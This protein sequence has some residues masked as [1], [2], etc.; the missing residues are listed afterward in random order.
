MIKKIF[1]AFCL[2][3]SFVAAKAQIPTLGFQIGSTSNDQGRV[4]R[5]APNGN[6]CIAGKF[7]GTMDLDPGSGV[8]NVTSSGQDD[9]FLACYSPSGAFIWGFKIGGYSWDG[10]YSMAIDVANNVVIGGYFQ[11]AGVDFDP[12]SGT[13]ILSYVG[14][15]GT[16]YN[17]DG[18]VAK[19]SASGAFQWA[20]VLGAPTVYDAT[21]GVA[22]DSVQN[23]YICGFFTGVMSP[24][25]SV[26]WNSSTTGKGYIIKYTPGGSY[27]WG[28]VFG[29][30]GYAADDSYPYCLQISGG[31]I[32]SC[33][34]NQGTSNFDPA[35]SSAGIL[36]ATGTY[37]GYFAKYDTA[38]N[39][40]TCGAMVGPNYDI[41][42]YLSIDS[43]ANMYI[44]GY[45]NSTSLTM[46][47]STSTCPGGGG[48]WDYFMC[49][50]TSTGTYQWGH[51]TG[52][53]ADDFCYSSEVMNGNVYFTGFFQNSM[54][55]D[56][57]SGTTIL[58]SHGN[59]DIFITKFDLGGNF[60]CGFNVGST[61]PDAGWGLSHD[62]AGELYTTGE[63]SGTAT[64]FDP[65]SSAFPLTSNGSTD[66]YLVK[67]KW[68]I[69]SS[70]TG[71]VTGDT[72][73]PGQ[74]A[75][76]T[77]HLSTGGAGPYTIVVNSGSGSYTYSGIV[78]GVPFLITPTP[79]VTTTYTVT[80]VILSVTS[81]CSTVTGIVSGTVTIVV[82][83]TSIGIKDTV[84]CNEVTLSSLTGASSY[85]W[86]F[87][88]GTGST[89]ANV[90]HTYSVAGTYPVILHIVDSLGCALNDTV[91]LSVY[92][93]PGVDLG[94][95]T[96]LCSG[97]YLLQSSVIYT[98]SPAYTWNTG[99]TSPSIVVTTSG[100]YSVSV[101]L[102][103]CTSTDAVKVMLL[104]IAGIDL[105]PDTTVCM[106]Q[107]LAVKLTGTG[108]TYR[109]QDGST[110]STYSASRTGRYYVTVN[111][112]GCVVS[113]TV[114][115]TFLQLTQNIPDTFICKGTPIDLLLMATP[116][117]GGTV[118]WEDG[119][120][121]PARKVHDSGTY[122]VYIKKFEC[123][124]LDTVHVV[125]G[126]CD[127]WHNVPNA[128]TPNDDG[129]NDVVA[130]R[131]QA[132]CT[133][134]GYLFSIY[135]R[136][137]ELVYTSDV[138]GKAWDGM[139]K[140]MPCDMGVYYYML[141]FFIGV[142]DKPVTEGGDIT[143]IR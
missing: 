90:I 5:V 79:T 109:W 105:G 129:L 33:G 26:S 65:G 82:R 68:T 89:A 96:I 106:N 2:L 8:T 121:N 143:L 53:S 141:Q 9:I 139:Y 29:L 111:S 52:S 24:T 56:P 77:L 17:G 67:Y 25:S 97:S 99:A 137:G 39:F 135:N 54:D 42:Y 30:P 86:T 126:Y 69:D 16:P 58:T 98:G 134:S 48:N 50:Y 1:L 38:G 119:S 113:D 40:V 88:D 41:A 20:H 73:C 108:I 78:P 85:S 63:F 59:T 107:T 23:V 91:N 103:G 28:K 74:S 66:A 44:S 15:S 101:T 110:A 118:L 14:G 117:N 133:V 83:P 132:G 55:I 94:P 7:T 72:I 4:T 131:I 70:F 35:G 138:P 37:D 45:T 12:G 140:G 10:V 142:H 49:K 11:S 22:V 93:P 102:N 104:D 62:A 19:Y 125:T 27:I 31:K 32:Y 76:M 43:L 80:S 21:T 120:T 100:T 3:L 112:G 61:G 127:C 130:P 34:I 128:F 6:I 51:V 46:G 116:P 18:F 84:V 47:S 81:L 114:N 92:T 136:W 87:G 57:G 95:D 71:Y 123:E 122:W 75:Y 64:D 124:I 60:I 115:I 36:T 13:A